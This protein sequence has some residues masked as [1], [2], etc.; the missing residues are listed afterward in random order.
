V[1]DRALELATGIAGASPVVVRQLKET[2]AIVERAD[3]DEALDREATC[4][5]VSYG[6]DDLVEGLAAVRERR[7]PRFT[8]R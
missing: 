4:Q 7:T 1:L 2:L 5:A 6:T 3:L 8:G